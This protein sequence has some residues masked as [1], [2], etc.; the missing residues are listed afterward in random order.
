MRSWLCAEFAGIY[1]TKITKL[2]FTETW[3]NMESH[4]ILNSIFLE[5]QE[6]AG[7]RFQNTL[8]HVVLLLLLFFCCQRYLKVN[9]KLKRRAI[10]RQMK[11]KLLKAR[12]LLRIVSSP[13]AQRTQVAAT[14]S[15]PSGRR[16]AQRWRSG[17]AG[18]TPRT[19]GP[20]AVTPDWAVNQEIGEWK[21]KVRG[22]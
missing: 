20:A 3:P 5:F 2:Q 22:P 8:T 7:R 15:A 9:P 6:I 17:K 13:T 21:C 14:S 18:S 11:N 1:I 4:G 19:S 10:L 12:E 16:T